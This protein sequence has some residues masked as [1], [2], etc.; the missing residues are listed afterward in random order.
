MNDSDLN[1]IVDTGRDE[2]RDR[3][4]VM[5]QRF[6]RLALSADPYATPP[7]MKWTAQQI[8]AHVLAVA[9]RYR[10]L[11]ETGDF[12]RAANPRELDQLNQEE[13]EELVVPIPELVDQLQALEHLMDTWFDNL[14][15]DFAGEF[16]YGVTVCA[17]IAQVNWLGELVFHGDDI[18]RAIG[19][20]WEISERDMLLY[21]REAVDMAPSFARKDMNP[22]TEICVALKVPDA[23]PYIIHVHDGMLDMRSRRPDDRPDAVLKVPA[24]TLTLMLL[25]R[26]GPATAIR[27]G[28]RIV[29][30][31]RP[32]RALKLQSC[33][34][35]V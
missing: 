4:E 11:A 7:G 23:R 33:I 26:I 10:S 17:V 6:Y 29:G 20:R 34:E 16:H 2:L 19:A 18:A 9:H 28:L 5:R 22:A 3:I 31:R 24:S 14:P 1:V 35:R 13:M 12:R 21:L 8:V 25:N 32:W 15:A 30:G 27:R